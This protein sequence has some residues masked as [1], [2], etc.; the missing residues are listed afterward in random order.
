MKDRLIAVAVLLLLAAFLWMLPGQKAGRYQLFFPMNRADPLDNCVYRLD[1]ITGEAQVFIWSN[2][3]FRL[4]K[5]GAIPAWGSVG[6]VDRIET[7]SVQEFIKPRPTYVFEQTEPPPPKNEKGS[8]IT[9]DF[10]P[11]DAPPGFVVDKPA[12]QKR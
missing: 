6:K 8:R 9:T 10:K 3:G 2:K 11:V 5:V 4:V 7:E 12:D 1:T